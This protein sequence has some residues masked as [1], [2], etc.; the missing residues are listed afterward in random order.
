MDRK[1]SPVV[2]RIAIFVFGFFLLVTIADLTGVVKHPPPRVLS[3][4]GNG[5]FLLLLAAV[6]H[7]RDGKVILYEDG[8]EAHAWFSRRELRR[9]EIPGLALRHRISRDL[10]LGDHAQRQKRRNTGPAAL[11]AC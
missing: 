2:I 10:S 1:T 8:I 5:A 4:L 11:L 6:F 9:D 7:G 3:L